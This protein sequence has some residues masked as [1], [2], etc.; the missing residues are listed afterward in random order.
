MENWFEDRVSMHG[1]TVH[2]IEEF[3]VEV[4]RLLKEGMKFRKEIYISNA[5]F[6]KNM[7]IE[8]EEKKMDKN[9]DFYELN[10]IKV[11]W[12]DVFS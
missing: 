6:K 7:K 5:G 11:I 2:L 12:R 10:Q 3:I 8:E 1:V 4:M 9:K